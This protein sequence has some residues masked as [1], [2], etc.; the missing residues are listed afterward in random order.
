MNKLKKLS[1]SEFS[2]MLNVSQSERYEKIS[3]FI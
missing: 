2:L 3:N 1:L